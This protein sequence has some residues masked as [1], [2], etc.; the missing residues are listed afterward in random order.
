MLA[1]PRPLRLLTSHWLR[2]RQCGRDRPNAARFDWL[3]LGR[4]ARPR[5][6]QQSHITPL[7]GGGSVTHPGY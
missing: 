2:R 6:P 5:W 3:R 7:I 4:S 1:E